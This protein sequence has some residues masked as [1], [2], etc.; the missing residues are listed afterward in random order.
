MYGTCIIW[1]AIKV[2]P[3]QVH[4][5]VSATAIGNEC[6]VKIVHSTMHGVRA[7]VTTTHEG[8]LVG[9]FFVET[10]DC[11]PLCSGI[12]KIRLEDVDWWKDATDQENFRFWYVQTLSV[13]LGGDL[14]DLK[15]KERREREREVEKKQAWE[16]RFNFNLVELLKLETEGCAPQSKVESQQFSSWELK[17]R[18]FELFF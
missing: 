16:L 4:Y 17:N 5:V 15:L 18:F 14:L 1:Y 7:R 11:P 10:N 9:M 13:I 12:W 2:L 3:W 6:G 8:F